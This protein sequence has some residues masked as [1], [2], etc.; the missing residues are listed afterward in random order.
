[1]TTLCIKTDTDHALICVLKDERIIA[2][3]TWH[4]GRQLAGTLLKRI[5]SMLANLGLGATDLGAVIIYRGPGSFTG[6]RIGVSVAN[7]LAYSLD[8]P[9]VGA[10]G[11]QWVQEGVKQ[12]QAGASE[13]LILPEYGGEA[14]ITM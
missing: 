9:I 5:D 6:L 12:L 11:E 7:T 4:S 2:E 13:R 8:I 3:D 14:H 1:M 10:S